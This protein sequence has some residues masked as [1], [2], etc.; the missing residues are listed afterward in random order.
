MRLRLFYS[1]FLG[2]LLAAVL[3]GC[4]GSSKANLKGKQLDLA[5]GYSH[6]IVMDVPDGIKITVT[7]GTNRLVGLDPQRIIAEGLQA[8]AA[9]GSSGRVPPLWDGHAAGRILEVL[10]RPRKGPPG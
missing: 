3:L 4:G 1:F 8:L 9:R 2:V 6:P 5:L 7:E 10:R